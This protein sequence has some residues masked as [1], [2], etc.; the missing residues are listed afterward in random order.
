MAKCLRTHPWPSRTHDVVKPPAP[1]EIGGQL[2]RALPVIEHHLRPHLLAVHLYG[3]AL[4]GGLK[5]LS[6]ID[7]LVTVSA[8]IDTATRQALLIDLLEVSA[9]PGQSDTLRALEVTVVVRD[10]IVPWRYPAT[11]ELQFGEW[12]RGDIL[13]GIF[14]PSMRDADLAILLTKA[15]QHSI[16][17]VG[18]SSDACFDPVP[19][20]DLFKALIDT[21]AQWNT[22]ADWEGDERNVVL[23]LARIWYTA[24][25]GGIASKELAADWA[26]ER[27]P[28]QHRPLLSG[29]RDAYLG[30]MEDRLTTQADQ[31]EA[32][33]QFVKQE[34]ISC[35][36]ARR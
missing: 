10:D 22:P 9:P 19:E 3:S 29:A 1:T 33:V 26:I 12:Q 7:L 24:A 6:D 11:R 34:A 20:S 30:K 36:A 23:A 35:L 31:M 14:E 32:F 18:P 21:L 13:T 15:S 25:T 4:E 17:L 2:A 28:V 8:R 16:A 5:P 27:L